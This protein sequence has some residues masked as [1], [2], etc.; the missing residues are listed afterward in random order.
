MSR[1]SSAAAIKIR[2][3]TD[4]V[5]ELLPC[6]VGVEGKLQLRVHGGDSNVDLRHT[7]RS[8]RHL[9]THLFCLDTY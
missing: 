1:T 4:L 8:R 2:V 5:K 9:M 6:C 7:K 3:W